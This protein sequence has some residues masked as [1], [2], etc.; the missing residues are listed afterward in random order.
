M[1]NPNADEIVTQ[2]HIRSF[3]QFGGAKAFNQPR[4]AGQDAQY[5][6]ITG[7]GLPE[8]GKID[9]IWVQDPA[10]QG[11]YRLVGQKIS[12][13]DLA[14]ATLTLYEKHGAIPRA[15][16]SNGC[17]FNLYDAAGSCRDLSDFLGGWT[18]YVLIY[19]GARVTTKDLG[20]RGGFDSDNQ[21]KDVLTLELADIYPIGG[22]S[23]G[24]NAKTLVDLEVIDVVYGSTPRCGN[25]GPED[26]GT[27]RVYAIVKSSGAGSPGLPAEIIYTTDGGITWNEANITGMG[28]NEDPQAIEVVGNYL[29]I[30]SKTAYSATT[31]GYYYAAIDPDTGIPGTWTKVTS[32]F[33]ANKSPNDLY[34]VS[35]REVWICG[36]GGYIYKAS[37][38]TTGVSVINAG[39]ATTQNLN[40]IDGIDEC[41]VSA[42]MAGAI[43]K[44][45][46][47]GLTWAATTS[48]PN[49]LEV[50]ALEVVDRNIYWV[51]GL[52]A[53][54]S[55]TLNGGATWTEKTFTGC[56]SG[57]IYDIRFPTPDVGYFSYASITPTASL[58]AS[59]DGGNSWTKTAPRVVNWPVC[60]KIN[61]VDTPRFGAASDVAAN[62]IIAGGLSASGS[63]GILLL[64]IASRL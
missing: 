50:K 37:D 31:G 45:V 7:V 44:S 19:S 15:L 9:P 20:D 13:P 4:F 34:V 40:R 29:V 36:D 1:P 51:G 24:D 57:N 60:N 54:L 10:R 2:K 41:I 49:G 26:D 62:N 32:G 63:D 28:A 30:L 58:F 17:Q 56:H 43:I 16:G 39:I 52:N 23:F 8:A 12:P 21:I 14:K 42:G 5:L 38:I 61:R 53:Y 64:G 22:L 35:P 48:T 59:W 33:V 11:K 18:D 47:R 25:C 55:V 3:I 46:N 6:T 27:Q